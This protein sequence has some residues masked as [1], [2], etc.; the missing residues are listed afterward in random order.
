MSDSKPCVQAYEKLCKG[1]F[2]ASNRVSTFLST[3]SSFNVT[4]CHLKGS[5]NQSSDFASLHP[6]VC[7]DQS[8]QVCVFVQST[9]ES[10]VNAITVDDVLSGTT[11]M[12]FINQ[13]AWHS[14]QQDCPNLR[15]TFAHLSKGTRPPRKAKNM[16]AVRRYLKTVTI[17]ENGLLIVLKSDPYIHQRKLIVAPESILQGRLTAI[18]LQFN[19]PSTHQ[20][21]KVFDRYFYAL[22]SASFIRSIA[23]QCSI[24]KSLKHI[25]TE[26]H[27]QSSSSSPSCPGQEFSSDVLRCTKQKIFVTRDM[28]SSFTTASI[29]HDETADNLRSALISTTSFLRMPSTTVRVDGATGFNALKED[30]ILQKNGIHL[31]FGRLKNKNKNPVIDKGIQELEQELLRSESDKPLTQLTLDTAL[32]TLNSRI[33]YQGLSAKEII[34]QRDQQSGSFLNIN[35][36]KLSHSQEQRGQQNHPHSSKSKARGGK[37]A[38]PAK[39]DI[40]DLVFIKQEGTKTKSREQYIIIRI[41]NNDI[42]LQKMNNGKFM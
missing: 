33:R 34:L 20:L 40:G 5:S 22:N 23:D 35:D 9:T 16:K 36:T 39:A 26:L 28:F 31:D 41:E 10:V 7:T 11:R 12:P 24:C 38:L 29:I 19:H 2:S 18:H 4:L 32:H 15:R 3:L 14:A 8:C 25:P 37:P 30:N 17:A 1:Q 42:I 13:S 6:N 27:E 21:Q